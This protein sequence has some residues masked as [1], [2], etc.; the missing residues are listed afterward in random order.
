MNN[1]CTRKNVSVKGEAMGVRMGQIRDEWVE[2]PRGH[3][4]TNVRILKSKQE[5]CFHT[6]PTT[7]A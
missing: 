7:T 6:E 3:V 1:N 2:E 4:D 5:G